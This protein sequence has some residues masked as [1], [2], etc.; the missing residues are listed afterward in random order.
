MRWLR[1]TRLTLLITNTLKERVPVLTLTT[2][3]LCL[4]LLG[5]NPA[6][7]K[8]P[9]LWPQSKRPQILLPWSRDLLFQK[10]RTALRWSLTR[11]MM[12]DYS[13]P[14]SWRRLW[15]AMVTSKLRWP[16][17]CRLKR[18]KKGDVSSVSL[19]ITS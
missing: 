11:K 3:G 14:A 5:T 19:Q 15:E 17:L 2:R 6:S 8:L 4:R 9:P 13:S 16:T 12:R 1:N 18:N 10:R 7:I